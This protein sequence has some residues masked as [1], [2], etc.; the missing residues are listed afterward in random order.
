MAQYTFDS[1]RW[2]KVRARAARA[3]RQFDEENNYLRIAREIEDLR[4][5]CRV[6]LAGDH[7]AYLKMRKALEASDGLEQDQTLQG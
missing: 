3:S 7:D 2:C 1:V 5:A 4:A 6:M